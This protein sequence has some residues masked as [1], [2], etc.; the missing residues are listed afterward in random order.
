MAVPVFGPCT[1]G[2][3]L[4]PPSDGL[5]AVVV[6]TP[7]AV[8]AADIF[9]PPTLAVY[10]WT[11]KPRSRR[12]Y[13]CPGAD[14][15]TRRFLDPGRRS[16]AARLIELRGSGNA[17][18][19]PLSQHSNG[20][21]I[22]WEIPQP[23]PAEVNYAT[24]Y[25]AVAATAAAALILRL[26]RYLTASGALVG[27]RLPLPER[28]RFLSALATALSVRGYNPIQARKF[29]PVLA[30]LAGDAPR[31]DQLEPDLRDPASADLTC[32]AIL[33][34]DEWRI[35]QAWLGLRPSAAMLAAGI[36]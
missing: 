5:Y 12:L 29:V 7:I 34:D 27:W 33:G 3:A 9:L 18:M 16:S 26:L 6:D 36:S 21:L 2:A 25:R 32:A 8:R 31:P 13:K 10:G 4:G 15:I 28:Q 11:S 30:R 22:D 14:E 24:L 19:I 1:I 35:V 17:L 20:E 23:M